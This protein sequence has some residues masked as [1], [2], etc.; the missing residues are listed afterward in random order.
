MD[1]PNGNRRNSQ[2]NTKDSIADP[3]GK[4]QPASKA[5]PHHSQEN[6]ETMKHVQNPFN[7]RDNASNQR[8]VSHFYSSRPGIPS[9][10]SNLMR[11]RNSALGKSAPTLSVNLVSCITSHSDIHPIRIVYS[12][13]AL[14]SIHSI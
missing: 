5:K 6:V 2:P 14:R 4:A 1:N 9:E 11:V 8:K 12:N 13:T 3:N 7:C 10:G